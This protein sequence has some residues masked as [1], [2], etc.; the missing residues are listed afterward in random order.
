MKV[1]DRRRAKL[2]Y[3]LLTVGD[4]LT[5]WSAWQI[6]SAPHFVTFLF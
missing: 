6:R 5:F 2:M 4:A 3:V 1:R